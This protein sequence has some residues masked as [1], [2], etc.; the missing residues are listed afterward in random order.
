MGWDLKFHRGVLAPLI[1]NAR[2]DAER[3]AAAAAAAPAGAPAPRVHRADR[4]GPPRQWFRFV[5]F[6]RSDPVAAP[7]TTAP[8]TLQA[9]AHPAIATDQETSEVQSAPQPAAPLPIPAETPTPPLPVVVSVPVVPPVVISELPPGVEP[10]VAPAPLHDAEPTPAIEPPPIIPPPSSVQTSPVVDTVRPEPTNEASASVTS[11]DPLP[12]A[13]HDYTYPHPDSLKQALHA[14]PEWTDKIAMAQAVADDVKTLLQAAAAQGRNALVLVGETHSSKGSLAIDLA[15]LKAV[16]DM[17][18]PGA[19]L[20]IETSVDR[21]PAFRASAEIMAEALQSDT[22]AAQKRI[23]DV[24]DL[25]RMR[26]HTDAKLV[27]AELLGFEL[28]CF[29]LERATN[30]R[31]RREKGMVEAI[32]LRASS[33]DKPIIVITGRHHLSQLHRKLA[34]NAPISVA[35]LDDRIWREDQFHE[36]LPRYSYLLSHEDVQC[37]RPA[38]ALQAEPFGLV[39]FAAQL[40]VDVTRSA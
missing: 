38:A 39:E 28:G 33:A 23:D 18:G 12:G 13:D 21:L 26:S 31:S 20:L 8:A 2:K 37:V 15:I 1:P 4:L 5:E 14:L 36:D 16:H 30:K 29:D 24:S 34:D 19:T 7:V 10:K 22:D 32:K 6:V 27:F 17:H 9:P 25:D 35:K 11:S 3:A 40:G